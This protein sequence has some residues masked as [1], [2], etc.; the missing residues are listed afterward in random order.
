[1]IPFKREPLEPGD[2]VIVIQAK[3]PEVYGMVLRV[4]KTYDRGDGHP[5]CSVRPANGGNFNGRTPNPL[6]GQLM[7]ITTGSL[8]C[9]Q[10]QLMRVDGSMIEENPYIG[11]NFHVGYDRGEP[12]A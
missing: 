9:F 12:T 7:R 8:K 6:T 4:T 10:D 3:V 5:S 1:M 11:T 2:L